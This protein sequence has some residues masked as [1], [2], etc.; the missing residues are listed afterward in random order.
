[1]NKGPN[2]QA[3]S[4]FEKLHDHIVFHCATATVVEPD[5]SSGRF[6]KVVYD[7]VDGTD[8]FTVEYFDYKPVE[9][10]YRRMRMTQGMDYVPWVNHE[11]YKKEVMSRE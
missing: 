4:L 9:I 10:I 5:D 7:G 6:F 2:W 3:R 11:R 8:E 1:M